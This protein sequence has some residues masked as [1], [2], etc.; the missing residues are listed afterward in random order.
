M[1]KPCRNPPDSLTPVEEV[2]TGK[3]LRQVMA[4]PVALIALIVVVAAA[5]IAG[6]VAVSPAVGG[7]AAAGAA[8]VWFLTVL[9]V[10]YNRAHK[11]FYAAYAQERGLTWQHDSSVPAA[12][13]L[14]RR[15]DTRRVDESFTG[16]LPGGLD[17][18][19]ALYSYEERS[20]GSSG[21]AK[22]I[23]HFTVVVGAL[24]GLETRLPG[25][26]VQR[27]SGFRFMDGAEDAFRSTE[28]IRLES[29]VLDRK[30]E[31]FAD[32]SCDANWL[33]QLFDPKF[34]DFLAEGAPDGFA[35]EVENGTL[36]INVNRYRGKA[37]EL[38]E[39][40]RAASTVAKRITD[41][42]AE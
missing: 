36:C 20:S 7:G 5:G 25:L 11:A 14:L 32:R 4:S 28:R 10:A 31:I 6:A 13:P 9:G 39:L 8:L 27:R 42:A 1:A 12:T 23:H 2:Q 16:T 21:Q 24:P 18:E 35:F 30:C 3:A 37:A 38:D 41:E 15:G 19:L 33:R 34:V 26:F 29:E 40:C 17:G 22:E